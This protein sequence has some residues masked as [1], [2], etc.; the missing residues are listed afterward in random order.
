MDR[1]NAWEITTWK[2]IG[3]FLLGVFV[4][5][6]VL[7]ADAPSWNHGH[8]MAAHASAEILW[9]ALMCAQT[10]L[11]LLALAWLWPTIRALPAEYGSANRSEIVGSS[12]VIFAIVLALAVVGMVHPMWPEYLPGH[13]YKLG[14]LTVLGGLVGLV[15]ARGVWIVH[16]G[17]KLLARDDLKSEQ[18]LRAFL[19]IQDDVGRFLGVLGAIIGLLV[20]S[21]GAQRRAV[22]WYSQHVYRHTHHHTHYGFELVLIYGFGAALLVAAVYL[23]TSL[24]LTE[25][26][27]KIRDAV[28]PLPPPTDDEWAERM[29]K[30]R[31]LGQVLQLEQGPLGRLKG[32]VAILTPLLASLVG[33]LLNAK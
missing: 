16:G 2:V 22:L 25:V 1:T 14:V 20:L 11:W 4:G 31:Q 8:R 18:S 19:T 29:E 12:A 13:E 26:G 24:T 15:A 17:L 27:G 32:S 21:T 9:A 3:V 7:Y 28:C 10:G 30:R 33:V 6:V 5:L 23:P